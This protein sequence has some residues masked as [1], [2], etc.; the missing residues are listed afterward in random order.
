MSTIM[1]QD[2]AGQ[3]LAFR[4]LV[5]EDLP[6]LYRWLNDPGVVRWWEGDDV[7][8]SAVVR[9]YGST[10]TDP[11]EHWV[12]MLEGRP[13]GWIQ[14]YATADFED[15][16]EVQQWRALGVTRTAAGI[17][18]LI[19][20]PQERGRG[21]GSAMIRVFVA[22]VVFGRHPAWTQVG[23]SPQLANV[24]SWRALQRAGFVGAGDFED[25]AGT[26]RLM[27][28]DRSSIAAIDERVGANG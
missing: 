28:R 26:C 2:L 25:E 8:W 7:S 3:H 27:L 13:V 15:E 9:E 10:S 21:W 12:A 22:E 24:A 19:G 4:R 16:R 18:Y 5:D 20:D 6:L 14:C 17:D 11:T 23:A 1:G